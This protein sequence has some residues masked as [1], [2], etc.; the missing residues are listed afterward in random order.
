M[1]LPESVRLT[2]WLNAVGLG[3]LPIDQAEAGIRGDQVA[4]HVVDS[5]GVL[6]LDPLHAV[7]MADAL[8]VLTSPESRR[9]MLALPVP[10]AL[11]GLRGTRELHQ[12]ALA[13]GSAV[14]ATSGGP[15]LVPYLVGRAVQWRVFAADPPLPAPPLPEAERLLREAVLR[16]GATLARLDVAGGPPPP[17]SEPVVLAPGYSARQ[18]AAADRA[19][20][21]LTA[22]RRAL[23]T[24]GASISSYEATVRS[25]ALREVR[26][27]AA[28]ALCAAVSWPDG[29]PPPDR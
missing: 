9:W 16:A 26:A 14:V 7:P 8:P 17:E 12:A 20:Q 10:G 18:R 5:D 29:A 22:C 19:A 6:G 11:G 27:A 21:L 28:E 23:Q 1:Q 13:A 2:T 4:H 25:A 15:G 3:V 24:D